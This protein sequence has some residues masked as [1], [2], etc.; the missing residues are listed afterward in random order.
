M[1]VSRCQLPLAPLCFMASD[2]HHVYIQKI[3]PLL[4]DCTLAN[5]HE[6]TKIIVSRSCTSQIRIDIFVLAKFL[7]L[8]I[9]HSQHLAKI[10]NLN[11]F[12]SQHLAK[13]L[14]LNIFHSQHLN[15]FHSLNR[16]MNKRLYLDRGAIL[17]YLVEGL[18]PL[19]LLESSRSAAIRIFDVFF[20]H[21]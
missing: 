8:N 17:L 19:L 18:E 1:S 14:N 6:K 11:I 4:L 7:N 15:S 2:H 12:H 3:T 13:I 16:G 9:F 10:L 20:N 5:I 21:R